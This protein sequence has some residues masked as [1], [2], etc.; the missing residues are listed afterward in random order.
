MALPSVSGAVLIP[1]ASG[2]FNR[3]FLSALMQTSH[4]MLVRLARDYIEYRPEIPHARVALDP[5]SRANTGRR[6]L[7]PDCVL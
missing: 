6:Y 4:A 2:L 5:T 3:A 7:G 1:G